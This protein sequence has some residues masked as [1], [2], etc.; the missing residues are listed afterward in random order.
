MFICGGAFDGLEPIVARRELQKSI[1]FGGE[2]AQ[3]S[4]SYEILSKVQP[5]DLVTYGFIPELVGRIPVLVAL[6]ELDK[7]AFIRILQ[8]PKN[9]LVKQY[10]EIFEMD[11]VRLTFTPEAL[12]RVADLAVKR[13]TGARGLRAIMENIM[14]DIEYELPSIPDSEKSGRKLI[15]TPEY[16]NNPVTP[17]KDLLHD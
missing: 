8:E 4:G 11:G 6:E 17:L 15:I 10:T 5:E 16:V 2:L 14:L 13:K 12:E 1:G 3:K 9:S 7:D